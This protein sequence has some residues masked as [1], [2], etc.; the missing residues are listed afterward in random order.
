MSFDR[1]TVVRV[2]HLARIRVALGRTEKTAEGET[3]YRT[4]DLQL[5]RDHL[6]SLSRSWSALHTIDERS[7]LHGETPESLVAKEA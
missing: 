6:L 7:P 3:F 2:A 1:S 4:L 5:Q